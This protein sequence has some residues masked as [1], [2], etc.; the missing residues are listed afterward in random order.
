MRR[1]QSAS[2]ASREAVVRFVSKPE[3]ERARLIQEARAICD[4]IFPPAGPPGTQDDMAQGGYVPTSA[5]DPR[6]GEGS[7]P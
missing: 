1:I 2:G 4:R 7:V 6:R 3:R 5:A